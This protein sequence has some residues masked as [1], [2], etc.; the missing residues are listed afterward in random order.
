MPKRQRIIEFRDDSENTDDVS[1]VSPDSV[2]AAL[3]SMQPA[4][5]ALGETVSGVL[6]PDHPSSLSNVDEVGGG[7]G[8]EVDAV[9]AVAPVNDDVGFTPGGSGGG[10]DAAIIRSLLWG[11]H[12]KAR[13]TGRRTTR[14]VA[15]V[16]P[17]LDTS[18]SF[19]VLP[20]RIPVVVSP[21][22]S[23]MTPVGPT[24]GVADV[25]PDRTE[26]WLTRWWY[27]AQ[28]GEWQSESWPAYWRYDGSWVLH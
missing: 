10:A 20:R 15:P 7:G 23:S 12:S 9:A 22:H 4:T 27:N 14:P 8:G 5:A 16:H 24:A 3:A 13:P 26:F 11:L 1:S 18:G 2:L 21:P 19:T 6:S 28:Y 25:D 17:V